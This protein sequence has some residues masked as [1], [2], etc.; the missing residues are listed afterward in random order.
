MRRIKKFEEFVLYHKTNEDL[1]IILKG[2]EVNREDNI[3]GIGADQAFAMLL[4]GA[5][6]TA[7]DIVESQVRYMRYQAELIR[8]GDYRSFLYNRTSRLSK[9]LDILI[10]R[11]VSDSETNFFTKDV[12]KKIKK[13]INSLDIKHSCILDE[14]E[15]SDGFNKVYLSNVFGFGSISYSEIPEALEKISQKLPVEGLI[16]AS[17][18]QT[19][20]DHRKKLEELPLKIDAMKN[21][22][23]TDHSW[24]PLVLR[25][26]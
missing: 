9:E 6:V 19:I 5:H 4:P 26:V 18:G 16:Y 21:F 23:L 22:R 17:N 14:V 3:L 10:R 25:K 11:K 24:N 12:F 15:R 20:L 2:L 1:S 7:M 8:E 13:N